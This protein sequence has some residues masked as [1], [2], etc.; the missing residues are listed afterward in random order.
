MNLTLRLE[1]GEV[2][3]ISLFL[4]EF[5]PVLGQPLRITRAYIIF[6]NIHKIKLVY[7]QFILYLLLDYVLSRL[8]Q[9]REM[10]DLSIIPLLVW[11]SSIKIH[12]SFI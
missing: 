1:G 7:E 11:Q 3:D 12:F 8:D 5:I 6:Y 4:R 2:C 9:A 10:E